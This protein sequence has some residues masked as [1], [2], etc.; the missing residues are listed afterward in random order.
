MPTAKD[1]RHSEVAGRQRL[2]AGFARSGKLSGRSLAVSLGVT[3]ALLSGL[4]LLCAARVVQ[5]AP[6]GMW[7]GRLPCAARDCAGSAPQPPAGDGLKQDPSLPAELLLRN[8]GAAQHWL[9]M[10]QLLFLQDQP[11]QARYCL[12]R[13]AALAPHSP[14]LLLEVAAFFHATGWP[15]QGLG[16]M[17]RV[18]AA[19]R[20]YDNLIFAF[21]SRAAD[22]ATVLRQGLPCD[23]SAARS[24]FLHVL[25]DRDSR[26]ARLVWDWLS[27]RQF[28]DRAIVRR[29]LRR[30]IEDGLYDEAAAVFQAFLPP[31]KAPS[32]G[33]RV[34]HGGFEAESTGAPLDW[35][36]TRNPHAEARRDQ[37]AAREGHWSLRIEFDGEANL[38]Y[39][40]VAQQVIVSPGRWK[41][42]AWIRTQGVTSDQGVGL[43]IFEVRP[44]P[45]WQVWTETVAGDSGWKP[46]EAA[47]TVPAP[48]RLVQ[49]EIVRRPSKKLDNKFG[50]VAWIDEVS[51]T[52]VAPETPLKDAS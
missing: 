32:G 44:A 28:A 49:L 22:V 4:R 40:Q 48:V 19:T 31:H 21:Y 24:Y 18:L 29:Y 37:A 36:V 3:L 5:T 26:G 23:P 2:E 34:T 17:S 25:E 11:E 33:D 47:V 46:L 41:L 1:R 38:E 8:P 7:C 16:L 42:R 30:L 14:P 6:F 10:G 12:E 45:E 52:P 39:R 9:R 27:S 20:V 15:S 50:G 51:L 43:R 35:V 13:A